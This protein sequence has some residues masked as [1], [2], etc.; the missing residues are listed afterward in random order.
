MAWTRIVTPLKKAAWVILLAGV[1]GAGSGWALS[2]WAL[3]TTYQSRS[4][5]MVIPRHSTGQNLM[6]GLVSGQQ[7]VATYAT[8][9][10][11]PAWLRSAGRLLP[12]PL[13]MTQL[14]RNVQVSSEPNTNLI[15]VVAHG[16][17]ATSALSLCQAISATLIA[18]AHHVTGSSTLREVEPA[19]FNPT[20]ISLKAWTLEIGTGLLGLLAALSVVIGL[21]FIN[22]SIGSAEDASKYTDLPILAE[23]PWVPGSRVAQKA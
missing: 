11:S 22:D 6:N 18:T 2:R 3:P 9:A 19:K 15:L 7:L 23:I 8:L 21:E 16:P 17:S 10:T 20:P 12:E 13:S 14:A 4:L 1:F 5:I